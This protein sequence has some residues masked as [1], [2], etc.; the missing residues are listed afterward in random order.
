MKARNNK[1]TLKRLT[2]DF[3]KQ[4]ILVFLAL[5]GTLIQVSLT[6]YLPVLIGRA[7]DAVLAKMSRK[8]YRQS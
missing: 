4:R 1:N 3:L 5:L 6:V 2:A 7:V 8:S